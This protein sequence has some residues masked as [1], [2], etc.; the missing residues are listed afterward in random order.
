MGNPFP[1][2]SL[3]M[4]SSESRLCFLG[5]K[6]VDVNSGFPH[7]DSRSEWRYS[8]T[9]KNDNSASCYLFYITISTKQQ[10]FACGQMVSFVSELHSW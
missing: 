3:V 7:I 4:I 9:L 5:F 6:K 2:G 10:E 8:K 1:H